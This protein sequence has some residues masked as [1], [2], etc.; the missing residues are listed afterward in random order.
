MR[1]KRVKEPV[2][3]IEKVKKPKKKQ[4]PCVA[5]VGPDGIEG[6]L[7]HI[8]RPL[9]VHL[10]IQ[11][12]DI[13]TNDMPITYD[14]NPPSDAIP[15]DINSNNPFYDDVE[16]FPEVKVEPVIAVNP[17]TPVTHDEIDYYAIK[18]N[19]LFQFND[20]NDRCFLRNRRF[21]PMVLHLR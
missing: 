2:E 21:F 14:P 19:L 13:P 9:I 18:S 15:Y 10:S 6:N 11:S 1:G 4:F 17:V 8:R 16:Q 3:K 5:I 20:Y 7:N 12:K